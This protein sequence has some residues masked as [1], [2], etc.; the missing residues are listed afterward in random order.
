MAASLLDNGTIIYPPVAK[1]QL[2]NIKSM[3][4]NKDFRGERDRSRIDANDPNEVEYVHRQFPSLSHQEVRDAI[5][6]NGPDRDAV[7]ASLEKKN[8]AGN[9]SSQH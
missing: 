4:D 2:I 5:V 6:S 8:K 3:A 9:E 7:M 1:I